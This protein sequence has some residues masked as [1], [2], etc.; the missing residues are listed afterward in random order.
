[1]LVS[2]NWITELKHLRK[3]RFGTISTPQCGHYSMWSHDP[4]KGGETLLTI[5]IISVPKLFL[6]IN[7]VTLL[8]CPKRYCSCRMN[9]S[10]SSRLTSKPM[11]CSSTT[12]LFPFPAPWTWPTW[13]SQ[14]S[15]PSSFS[16]LLSGQ[17]S[18]LPTT[19]TSS[20]LF[21]SSSSC[22]SSC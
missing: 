16:S 13:I 19:L 15:F 10:S 1:M 9:F 7:S 3:H 5:T 20:L 8:T 2:K 4:R 21:S 14:I 11:T 22:P 6:G 17:F 12:C 18:S